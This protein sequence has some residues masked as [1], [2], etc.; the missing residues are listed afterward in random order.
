[1]SPSSHSILQD[2]TAAGRRLVA[3]LRHYAHRADVIFLASSQGG[4]PVAYDAIRGG[5]IPGSLL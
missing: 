2:R 1:M 4:V 3:T 5:R